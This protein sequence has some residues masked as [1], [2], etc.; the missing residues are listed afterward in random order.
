MLLGLGIFFVALIGLVFM[1]LLFLI[2]RYY[3]KRVKD[4]C[5]KVYN[6]LEKQLFWT[7]FIRYMIEGNLELSH[8]NIFFLYFFASFD[9][10]EE[11]MNTLTR[12]FF[13]IL[14]GFFIIWS[15]VYSICN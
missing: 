2:L 15:A 7:S 6:T 13:V 3:R 1:I 5:A 9:T 11:G 8:E 14:I 10:Q 4:G 12:T